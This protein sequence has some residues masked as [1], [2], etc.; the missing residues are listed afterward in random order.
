MSAAAAAAL[1]F[2]LVLFWEKKAV[3]WPVLQNSWTKLGVHVSAEECVWGSLYGCVCVCFFFSVCKRERKR[4]RGREWQHKAK[5]ERSE[6]RRERVSIHS[7]FVKREGKQGKEGACEQERECVCV[8]KWVCMCERK[9]RESRP[10]FFTPKT[11][12]FFPSF[13]SFVVLMHAFS[14]LEHPHSCTRTLSHLP[15]QSLS[16]R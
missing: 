5:W 3:Y 13:L 11:F 8:R 10:V 16:H 1:T 9:D 12:L 7:N 4:E 2:R 14:S 15:Q 6:L